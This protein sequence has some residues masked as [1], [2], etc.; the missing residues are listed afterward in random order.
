[1]SRARRATFFR[2]RAR[3]RPSL[4]PMLEG[5]EFR[6]VPAV[7]NV[8]SE[9]ALR[10]AIAT[11]D[12]NN[13]SANTINVTSPISLSDTSAGELVIENETSNAKTLLIDGSSIAATDAWATRVFEILAPPAAVRRWNSRAS[14]SQGAKRPEVVLWAARPRLAAGS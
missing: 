5:L 2:R 10:A 6:I 12:S 3:R 11:A 4:S 8:S 13:S 14:K 9:A 7:F 1:M